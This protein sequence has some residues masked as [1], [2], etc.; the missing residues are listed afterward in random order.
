MNNI[1]YFKNPVETKEKLI[2]K[3]L[4]VWSISKFIEEQNKNNLTTN[5]RN[6]IT[7]IENNKK[8]AA[9]T[10]SDAWI[11]EKNILLF[12]TVAHE[13]MKLVLTKQQ[14]NSYGNVIIRVN[15]ENETLELALTPGTRNGDINNSV[16]YK[17]SIFNDEELIGK[18]K[19]TD[20]LVGA[21]YVDLF[22]LLQ[23]MVR[24]MLSD[25]HDTIIDKL[26]DQFKNDKDIVKN[27]QNIELEREKEK[28][29]IRKVIKAI[30]VQGSRVNLA[31]LAIVI[32][33]VVDIQYSKGSHLISK[34][35]YDSGGKAIPVIDFTRV[36]HV[37]FMENE[38]EQL[39]HIL[40]TLIPGDIKIKIHKN[41]IAFTTTNID[42]SDNPDITFVGA[43]IQTEEVLNYMFDNHV[44][45]KV[46]IND[47]YRIMDRVLFEKYKNQY[48]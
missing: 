29:N 46:K 18:Y 41:M 35:K 34:I 40:Q 20:K 22:P 30:H 12:S 39:K 43:H 48:Y 6:E 37:D 16:F 24:T 17:A 15:N 25:K 2:L 8:V 27:K 13:F 21:G 5:L 1:V 26:F 3:S 31:K 42:L 4:L 36:F 28:E 11:V 7:Q 47:V 23:V 45:P 32:Y 44:A 10:K 9:I 19:E 14:Y 38:L 33:T